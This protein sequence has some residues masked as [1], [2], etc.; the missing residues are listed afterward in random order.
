MNK[1]Y[2]MDY[3]QPAPAKEPLPIGHADKFSD[4]MDEVEK[5]CEQW[6]EQLFVGI[7]LGENLVA[8][9]DSMDWFTK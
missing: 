4:A 3:L 1:K 8:I 9:F 6:D 2:T 7:W 5:W